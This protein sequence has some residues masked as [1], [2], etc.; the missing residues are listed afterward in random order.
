[1]RLLTFADSS[2]LRDDRFVVVAPP[3]QGLE[4]S[5][6]TRHCIG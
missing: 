6:D 1:M 3:A 4:S 5:D 2:V